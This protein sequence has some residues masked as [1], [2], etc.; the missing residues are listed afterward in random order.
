MM[1]YGVQASTTEMLGWRL[2]LIIAAAGL[3]LAAYSFYQVRRTLRKGDS[4]VQ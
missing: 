2:S 4:E 1:V 3:A